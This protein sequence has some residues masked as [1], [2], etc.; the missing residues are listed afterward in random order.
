MVDEEREN[1]GHATECGGGVVGTSGKAVNGFEVDGYSAGSSS[2]GIRMYKRRKQIKMSNSKTKLV[3]DGKVAAADL[4]SQLP[5]KQTV[6]VPMD[7]DLHNFSC[8]RVSYP[9]I[10]SH[11][12]MSGI[13]DCSLNG[14][15]NI[16][17]E[18]L[19]QPL[20]ES[21]GGLQEC[22]Q[23]A[24]QSHPESGCR[25]AVKESLHSCEEKDK[26]PSETGWMDNGTHN[27]AK[28]DVGAMSDGSL[29]QSNRTNTD[30]CRR[31]FF[32]TIMSEKFAQLC[33]LL[34]ENFQGI[35]VDNIMDISIINSRM[36]EGTY[37]TSPMLF[38]SD[39]Q[40]LWSKFQKIGAEMV[41]LAKSLSSKSNS[42]YREQFPTRE[43]DLHAKSE[44]TEPCGVYKVC[45]CRRCG[46]KADGRNCLVCDSCEEMYHVSCIEPAVEEIPSKSWYCADCT[47]NGIESTHDNCAVCEKLNSARPPNN[48]LGDDFLELE[49]NSYGLEN[50]V[51][52]VDRCKVCGTE[53]DKCE[54][55]MV[56]GH[57]FC[58]HKYYH[59]RCLKNKQLSTYGRCWY[60]PSCLCRSCL[61]DRDDDKIVLCDGCD[62]A[63]HI[64]CMQ[65]PRAAIPK[66]KWFCRKCDEGIRKIRKVK[67]AY[68]N[69]QNK[70]KQ[71]DDGKGPFGNHQDAQ[72]DKDEEFA[73]KSGGMDMLLTA[74]KTLNLEEK[75]AAVETES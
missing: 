51:Q 68:E 55:L 20:S 66:G 37:E 2:E 25:N 71:R 69:A 75:M 41:T 45:A 38:H 16:V 18:K 35:K 64:Y 7:R 27:V 24:L 32:D 62:H 36:K 14:W 57:S 47:T 3:E 21:K 12:V 50:L 70:L 61:T 73:D 49:E 67:R 53:V 46:E 29:S 26:D 54:R 9:G 5:E 39:M 44:Q 52:R 43:S 8:E 23:D 63:Y 33:C 30:L 31:A 19:C 4:V 15:R 28:G 65:P 60:C 13:G 34:S 17:L 48:G 22:I 11:A 72:E 74:A 6:E 1:D 59:V 58:P 56:C 40:Q 10:D 42:S